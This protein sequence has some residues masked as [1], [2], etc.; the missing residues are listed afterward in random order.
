MKKLLKVL[1]V[2]VCLLIIAGSVFFIIT[3]LK[4]S[5]AP[6]AQDMPQLEGD[7]EQSQEAYDIFAAAVEKNGVPSSAKMTYTMD[8]C[9]YNVDIFNSFVPETLVSGELDAQ[10]I[11]FAALSVG[12]CSEATVTDNGDSYELSF[13]LRSAGPGLDKKCIGGYM[14]I[15]PFET[16]AASVAEINPNLTMLQTGYF[17]LSDGTI[18]AV[19]DKQSGE[20]ISVTLSFSQLY[21]DTIKGNNAQITEALGGAVIEQSIS[22][23]VNVEYGF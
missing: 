7:G 11:A 9:K 18:A 6:A 16:C 1:F 21:F 12:T 22:Y 19:V 13:K 2:I 5:A 3:R 4:S 10:I 8:S 15:L 17:D 23:A 20:F 14:N